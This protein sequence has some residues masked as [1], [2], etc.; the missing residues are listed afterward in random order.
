MGCIMRGAGLRAQ[1][2]PLHGQLSK[3][4]GRWAVSAQALLGVQARM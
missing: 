2:D 1:R 4:S 3:G